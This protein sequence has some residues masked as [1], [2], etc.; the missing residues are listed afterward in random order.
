MSI[1]LRSSDVFVG[2]PY[3]MMNYALLLDAFSA[4]LECIPGTLHFTLAHAHLYEKHKTELFKCLHG[5]QEKWLSYEEVSPNLPAWSVER[6]IS[7][8]EEYIS[9]MKTLAK[10]VKL[11]SW[12]PKPE[13]VE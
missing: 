8:P 12:T 5:S 10:R 6:I 7:N 11:H 1:F 3:D 13:L 4:T 9:H 2:L